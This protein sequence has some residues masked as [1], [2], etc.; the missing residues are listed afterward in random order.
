MKYAEM[1]EIQS[2]LRFKSA[3]G[4]LVETTGA[5]T[6]VDTRD[7]YVHEV[8]VVEGVGQGEK[9]YHNLDYAQPLNGS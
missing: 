3:S 6:F 9:F 5:T 2:G 7:L 4:L 8:V 1:Q